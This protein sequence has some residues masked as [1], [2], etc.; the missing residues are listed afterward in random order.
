MSSRTKLVC[1]PSSITNSIIAF[2]GKGR[3]INALSLTNDELKKLKDLKLILDFVVQTDHVQRVQ[4]KA[5]L[6]NDPIPGFKSK[7]N[8]EFWQQDLYLYAAEQL[9][10]LL[11]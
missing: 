3:K 9:I 1:R 4:A 10:H 5:K 6:L 11:S 2:I 8:Q 7:P